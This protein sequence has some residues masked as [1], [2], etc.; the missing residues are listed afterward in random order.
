[1][2]AAVNSPA[3]DKFPTLSPDGK[4]LF[5]VSHRGADRSY[6]FSDLTYDQ[7]MRRNLGPRNGEGDVYWVSTEVI[8]RLRPR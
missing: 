1:L 3:A 8:H 4:Y 7:L 2:G 6:V 5:F